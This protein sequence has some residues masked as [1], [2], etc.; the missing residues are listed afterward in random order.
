MIGVVDSI[1]EEAIA[2]LAAQGVAVRRIACDSRRVGPGDVF[3]AWPGARHDARNYIIDAVGRGASGVIWEARAYRFPAALRVANV[4][5][6]DLQRHAGEIAHLVYGKPSEAMRLIGI[7]GTNGKTSC[8]HWLADALAASGERC[9]VVGTLGNG[10]PGRLAGSANTTPDAITLHALL[11]EWQRD[12][13]AACAM[14]VSSI[15][16]DQ[17]RLS[18]ARFDTAV[19]TNLTHDHLDYHGD[20][21]AYAAAKARLFDWPDLRAAVL[22]LDDP[23]GVDLAER[24]GAPIK[25][26]Y[27]LTGKSAPGL[28]AIVAARDVHATPT[29]TAFTLA[30]GED[31]QRVV[32]P[33]IGRHNV[34]NLLAVAG[35]L[36]VGDYGIE[37]IAALLPLLKA[38]PG[39]LQTLGGSG[40][41]LVVID[42]AHTPDALRNVLEALRPV[43]E[44]RGGRLIAVFG[45]GG[46]RDKGKRPQMGEIAARLADRVWLTSDNPRHEEPLAIIADISAGVLAA[47][48]KPTVDADR[49]H[50][51]RTA[52]AAAD[53]RDVVLL[54]GKGHEAYQEIAGERLP[55]SDA[56]TAQRSLA[57][58]LP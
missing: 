13:I 57:R 24:S 54:A 14:E 53:A 1:A 30:C 16:L 26:G 8:S 31:S 20:M 4:G 49:A 38:P 18:G 44:S 17:H 28:S 29:G 35:A 40:V 56:I 11:A 3:M 33:L 12:S 5:V 41:P 23:F 51:V 39:R 10:L 37:R 2:R 27:T 15:G 42:Y 48:V 46:N 34:Q 19:F 43:A 45:C 47:G 9:A 22:N 58:E 52:I 25:I 32:V 50:A 7:T 36:L 55:Y 21:D 6:E